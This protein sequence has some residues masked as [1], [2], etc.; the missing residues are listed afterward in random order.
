MGSI[1]SIRD[2]R[3]RLM[4]IEGTMPRLDGIPAG[5]AFHPR[6]PHA[7]ERCRRERPVLARVEA[8]EAACWRSGVAGGGIE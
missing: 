5:C 8:T 3:E 4:Q 7:I 6:C 2:E 1:P